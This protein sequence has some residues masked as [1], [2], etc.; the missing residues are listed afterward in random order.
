MKIGKF[1]TSHPSK[2]LI[3][4]VGKLKI[5]KTDTTVQIRTMKDYNPGHEIAM[6]KW[7]Q[8]Q[9]WDCINKVVKNGTFYF[10][11]DEE[12]LFDIAKENLKYVYSNRHGFEHTSHTNKL[13]P[14]SILDW[15][16]IGESKN[17][18]CSGT[19]FCSTAIA[20]RYPEISKIH[21]VKNSYKKPNVICQRIK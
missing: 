19:S 6:S 10:T 9:V 1:L 17:V 5:P 16:L 7:K 4:E 18:V 15:Y 8:K 12:K 20:R 11:S 2:K 21:F 14:L 3:Q 13:I